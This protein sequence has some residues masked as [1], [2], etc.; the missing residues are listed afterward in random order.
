MEQT[1]QKFQV[2]DFVKIKAEVKTKEEKK[3]VKEDTN[4][5]IDGIFE[6]IA[7]FPSFDI[8][9]EPT[10]PAYS[11]SPCNGD[12]TTVMFYED[13][14]QPS[15]KNTKRAVERETESFSDLDDLDE[16]AVPKID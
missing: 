2:G 9:G 7:Y 10:K 1:N 16:L 13:E 12:Y 11:I 3:R 6:V 5:T 15:R 4:S 8:A 14:L